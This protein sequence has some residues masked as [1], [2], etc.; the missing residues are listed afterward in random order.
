MGTTTSSQTNQY[1]D[2]KH[3]ETH[4]VAWRPGKEVG[5]VSASPATEFGFILTFVKVKRL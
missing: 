5:Q 1:G 4:T 3:K 2:S